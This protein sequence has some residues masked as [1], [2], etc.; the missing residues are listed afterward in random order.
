MT[1]KFDKQHL[2][3]SASGSVGGFRV[4]LAVLREIF[5]TITGLFGV[6]GIFGIDLTPGDGA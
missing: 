4:V 5:S 1:S 6:L 2:P 3:A